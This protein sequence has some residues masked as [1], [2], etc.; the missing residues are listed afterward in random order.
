MLAREPRAV[1]VRFGIDDEVG[2]A[3]A[4]E[5]HILGAMLADSTKAHLLEEFAQSRSVG[6]GILDEFEAG[7]ADGIVPKVLRDLR[8]GRFRED[9]RDSFI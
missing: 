2:F 9:S 8:H 7:G 3:L 5:G 1:A 6:R 4:V